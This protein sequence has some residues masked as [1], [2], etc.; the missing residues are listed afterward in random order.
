MET[1]STIQECPVVKPTA[2]EEVGGRRR[3]RCG[4]FRKVGFQIQDRIMLSSYNSSEKCLGSLREFYVSSG[5]ML[6]RKGTGAT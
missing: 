6:G 2:Q 5:Q 4:Q 1:L 3:L